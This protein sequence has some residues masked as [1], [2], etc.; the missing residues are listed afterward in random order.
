MG[1]FHYLTYLAWCLVHD[2]SLDMAAFSDRRAE[3]S[4]GKG[5]SR[6]SIIFTHT[7]KCLTQ[8]RESGFW[9]P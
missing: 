3:K 5:S 6:Q 8:I 2:A 7:Q 9:N 1:F 4:E